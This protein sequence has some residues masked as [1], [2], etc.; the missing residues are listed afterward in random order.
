[1]DMQGGVHKT[2]GTCDEFSLSL[3]RSHHANTDF[4]LYGN[5]KDFLLKPV[6]IFC[7]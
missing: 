1:M 4:C 3:S 6:Y 5:E 7:R 2:L